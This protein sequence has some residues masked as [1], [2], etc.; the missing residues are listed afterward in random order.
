MICK[1]LDKPVIFHV[2]ITSAQDLK[3][4]VFVWETVWE[5]NRASITGKHT[6]AGYG[7]QD[8]QTKHNPLASLGYATQ[9][10]SLQH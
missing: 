3:A 9:P 4:T 10:P 7:R 8:S 5:A 2:V 6:T 1:I